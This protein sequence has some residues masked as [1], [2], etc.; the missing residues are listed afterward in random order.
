[1][2]WG[3]WWN[4]DLGFPEDT[5]YLLGFNEP[6]FYAQANMCPLEAANLWRQLEQQAGNRTLVSPAIGPCGGHVCMSNGVDWMHQFMQACNGC[7]IDYLAAHGYWCDHWNTMGYLW[8]LWNR[9]HKPIWFTEFACPQTQSVADQLN[10]MKAV[11]PKLEE[12]SY[13]Y[14]YSWFATRVGDDGW[15]TGAVNLLELDSSN[16][17]ELGQYYM[18][19]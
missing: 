1:M 10:Y 9:F 12:T 17:T 5:E 14:R 6:N 8:D 19:F 18:N 15:V 4:D 7:R 2:V 3:R 16:L 13:V 11:L